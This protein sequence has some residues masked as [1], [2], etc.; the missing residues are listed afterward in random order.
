ML[1]QFTYAPHLYT[2]KGSTS[3]DDFGEG[4]CTILE[5]FYWVSSTIKVEKHCCDSLETRNIQTWSLHDYLQN[6]TEHITTQ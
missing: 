6:E 3:C 1:L 4:V 5:I 2:N